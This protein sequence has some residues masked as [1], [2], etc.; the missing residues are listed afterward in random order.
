[1]ELLVQATA[2][3]WLDSA[4]PTV[5]YSANIDAIC[6]WD[7]SGSVIKRI[8]AEFAIPAFPTGDATVAQLTGNPLTAPASAQGF[9]WGIVEVFDTIIIAQ[10][11]FEEYATGLTW[12]SADGGRGDVALATSVLNSPINGDIPN[13]KTWDVSELLPNIVPETTLYLL[14]YL[15][16]ESGAAR[17][18]S[19][20]TLENTGK[21][22]LTLV[23]TVPDAPIVS[24]ASPYRT[25][26]RGT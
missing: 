22:P 3:T 16:A 10:A 21:T 7:S 18:F 11:T 6:G 4:N 19:M 1:M 26:R 25:R 2:E 13:N 24:G 14:A 20:A 17:Q 12:P 15:E 23:F 9:R 8:L 5:N